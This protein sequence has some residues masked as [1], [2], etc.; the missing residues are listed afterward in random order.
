ML[1][2]K[3]FYR[4]LVGQDQEAFAVTASVLSFLTLFLQM[5]ERL[6][7]SRILTE[8]VPYLPHYQQEKKSF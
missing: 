3:L 7:T 8:V 1:L 2:S 5:T 4:V 6:C